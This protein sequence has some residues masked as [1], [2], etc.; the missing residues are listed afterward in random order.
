MITISAEKIN[1]VLGTNIAVDEIKEIF[2][3]LQ[4]ETV[5]ENGLFTVTVPTRR[6]DIAI[7]EDLIEEVARL[8][9]YDYIPS[10]LPEGSSTS[11][12]LTDYQLKR[13]KVRRFLKAPGFIKRSHI[14]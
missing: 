9:G 13:R 10:T 5:E 7:E 1:N 8:Y 3:R 11:G 4:F 6:G 14:H 12:A 2:D